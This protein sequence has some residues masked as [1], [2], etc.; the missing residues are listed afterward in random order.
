MFDPSK[1]DV[2][3][4]DTSN[5]NEI[6]KQKIKADKKLKLPD[7]DVPDDI[8]NEI[9]TS[10]EPKNLDTMVLDNNNADE[11]VNQIIEKE[12]QVDDE[13]EKS[14]QVNNKHVDT[15]V[16]A[17]IITDSELVE[18]NKEVK[19]F[20]DK[21]IEEKQ[22]SNNPDNQVIDINLQQIDDLASILLREK[23][24][25]VRLEP[26]DEVVKVVFAKDSVDKLIKFIKYPVYLKLLIAIKKAG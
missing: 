12:K 20:K 22:D 10:Q 3:F 9:E 5:L 24:D 16:L 4:S 7:I 8:I 25:Y 14:V 15:A 2:D 23:Y 6:E 19:E 11:P 18:N 17:T 26:N 1:L 13:V 21:K